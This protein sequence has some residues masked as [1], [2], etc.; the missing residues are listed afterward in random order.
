MKNR[1]SETTTRVKNKCELSLPRLHASGLQQILN[2][3]AVLE[4]RGLVGGALV[5]SPTTRSSPQAL[6]F[7]FQVQAFIL[8][9]PA[10]QGFFLLLSGFSHAT[11]P[12]PQRVKSAH[13]MQPEHAN[14]KKTKHG[15]TPRSD[16]YLAAQTL[17]NG[18]R[19]DKQ[20][21]DA[22]MEE[23]RAVERMGGRGGMRKLCFTQKEAVVSGL[24]GVGEGG[25]G[26]S[27][28]AAT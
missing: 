25:E 4:A 9:I 22:E 19:A 13:R 14:K 16:E 18:R 24:W 3:N 21:L 8:C 10:T 5:L 26:S 11:L 12:R 23:R 1:T 27:Q 6:H 7:L 20:S 17:F 2:F 15:V 28:T